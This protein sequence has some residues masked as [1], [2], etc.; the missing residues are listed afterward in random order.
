MENFLS[1][2]KLR[3][4]LTPHA[5]VRG[6]FRAPLQHVLSVQCKARDKVD[7]VYREHINCL[8]V[9]THGGDAAVRDV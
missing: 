4:A 5:L 8:Q 7:S 9:S 2:A 3:T 6:W 1:T